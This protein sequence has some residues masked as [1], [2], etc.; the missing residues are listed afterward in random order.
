M[1]ARLIALKLFLDELGVSDDIS[2]VENRKMIQKAVYLGQYAGADLGYRFIWHKMGPFSENLARDY[3]KLSQSIA[4]GDE[5]YKRRELVAANQ[6]SLRSIKP[7]MTP[8]PDWT[9]GDKA[10]ANWL[11]L[12]ASVHY[13]DNVTRLEKAEV[14]SV[15]GDEKPNL[16]KY[17]PVAESRIKKIKTL[18]PRVVSA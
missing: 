11:E 15:L 18:S 1:D 14:K 13:L 12:V 6:K 8:P 9:K 2:K 7:L 16:A 3:Y 17:I 5:E 4:I 10:R